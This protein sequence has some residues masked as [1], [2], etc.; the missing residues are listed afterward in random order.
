MV[1][2]P[3]KGG[4]PAMIDL[5]AGQIQLYFGNLPTSLPQVKIGR[6]RALAVT[7]EKRVAIAPEYPTV[8]EAGVPGFELTPWYG[9]ITRAGTPPDI[10]A[11]LNRDIVGILRSPEIRDRIVGLGGEPIGNTQAE[12][13]AFLKT[14]AVKWGKLVRDSGAR[15]E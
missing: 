5:Q 2:V 10:V 6:V 1:H 3:Y 13:A 9:V 12:F 14:A 8:A 15:P 4:G 11:R 7:S